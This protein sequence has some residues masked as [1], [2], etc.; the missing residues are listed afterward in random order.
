LNSITFR[1]CALIA[2]SAALAPWAAHAVGTPAGAAIQNTAQV[3]YDVGG[4]P[5]N[6]SSNP[7]TLTVAEIIN[8]NVTAQ[9]P[10]VTVAP[11]AANRVVVMRVTNTGN[12][13]ETF[14]LTGNSVVNGDNFDPIPAATL[15]YFD[16]D[17]S[18]DLSAPD[19]AYA[20]GSNDPI[21]AADTA[22][23]ILVV[24]SIPTGLPNGQ[25]GITQLTAVSLTGAGAPGAVYA[26]QG[27]GGTDA[28]LGASGGTATASGSYVIA[29]VQLSAVKSQSVV[30]QFGGTQP[31][32]GARIDYQIV[33]TPAGTGTAANVNFADGIPANTTYV[34]GS[35]RVNAVAQ[36]DAADAD[37]GRFEATPTPMV[38][39][40][41]GDLTQA[42][43]AQ[44][45]AFSVTIN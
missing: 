31:V 12:A 11:G 28:V 32:P 33:I 14:R 8:V 36:T 15:L 43:G 4:T 30:D 20:S 41:L 27:A 45:I 19:L 2:A 44:T 1:I 22:V 21:L 5:V 38:R 7:T 16:T 23:T 3:S 34:A 37:A 10:T 13:T 40:N 25:I 42:G 24:N 18:G 26:G 6:T 39:A 17:G 29:S 35:L 9:T